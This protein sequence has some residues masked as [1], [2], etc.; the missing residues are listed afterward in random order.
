MADPEAV[1]LFAIQ[2]ARATGPHVLTTVS[3]GDAAFV[4]ELGADEVDDYRTRAF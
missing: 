4:K 2:I 1:G 3:G